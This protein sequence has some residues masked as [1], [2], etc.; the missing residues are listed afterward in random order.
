VAH[1]GFPDQTDECFFA[2]AS[3]RKS[4]PTDLQH[5]WAHFDNIR[6]AAG[7]SPQGKK[8]G[9]GSKREACLKRRRKQ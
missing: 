3:N 5:D 1:I 6:F 9:A 7:K 8:K 4:S 2:A